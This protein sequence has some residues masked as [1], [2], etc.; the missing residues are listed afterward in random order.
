[1]RTIKILKIQFYT[2]ISLILFSCAKEKPYSGQLSDFRPELQSSLKKLSSE[3]SIPVK[4]SVARN[5]IE[6]NCTKKELLQ[7]LNCDSPVLRIL[8]YRAIVDRHE[9]DSFKI[10]LGHLNDTIK[11]TWWYYDDAAG[12][13]SVS[14]MMVYKAKET[15]TQN[16]KNILVDSILL[17]HPYLDISNNMI[18]DIEPNEKHYSLIKERCKVK[19]DRCGTQIGACYALSKFKKKKDLIFLKNIFENLEHPCEYWIFKAIEN[20]PNEIYFPILERYFKE[21]IQRQKQKSYNDLKYYC[22]A[23]AAYKNKKSLN[24]LKKVLTKTA[25][26]DTYYFKLDEAN[27]FKAVN[28]HNV[29]IYDSL[30]NNL[31]PKMN[32]YVIKHIN[33]LDYEDKEYW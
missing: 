32:K 6:E 33:T 13:F 9:T 11:V 23:V 4:D 30:Y 2:L 26:S 20:N 21:N 10:L 12:D 3:K 29:T 18:H 25:Y 22:R 27:V 5:Y 1:M 7:L 19:T 17:N 16:Q 15:L 31:Q 28:K 8:S 24:L 14:D